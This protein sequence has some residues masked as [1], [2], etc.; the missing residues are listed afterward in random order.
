M[1]EHK[2]VVIAVGGNALTGANGGQTIDDQN[3][4]LTELM[5]HVANMVEQG[6]RVVITYG[7]GPQVGF[8][9]LRSES[10][11]QLNGLH[12]LPLLNC[13][14]NTQGGIGFQIQQALSN[15][16]RRRHLDIPVVPVVTRVEVSADDEGFSNPTKFVGG[17]YTPEEAEEEQKVHPD[18]I[19][20]ADSNRG[21]RRV[22]A[23]PVPK[24]ILETKAIRT[25]LDSGCIVLAVGG[26]GVPV[27]AK[28]HEYIGVDAVIDKDLST[29]LLA[30][31]LQADTLI[32][33]TGVEQVCINFGTPEEK[34]LS[35]VTVA[36]MQKYSAEGHFPEGSMG[37][38]IRSAM[39]FAKESGGEVIITSPQA[40][41][42]ALN[43][44]KG[45][46][47]VP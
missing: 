16:L 26:G 28:D 3:E 41:H 21:L 12:P 6:V 19:L 9:M 13:V 32:I 38:K 11:I 42:A 17:F 22:V 44:E 7:N 46:H 30:Q 43:G 39:T 23:S 20:K 45:T 40:M 47:I 24:T 31:S 25:L 10:A 2:L 5:P 37:P 14:A 1:A 4:A 8:M 35:T 27:V 29:S 33:T 36:E 15:E 18:W 34:R